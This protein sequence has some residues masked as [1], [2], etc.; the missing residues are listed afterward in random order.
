VKDVRTVWRAFDPDLMRMIIGIKQI[1]KLIAA[2]QDDANSE[3]V[4]YEPIPESDGWAGPMI[5]Y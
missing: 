3:E 2:P 1:Q 4:K 5:T